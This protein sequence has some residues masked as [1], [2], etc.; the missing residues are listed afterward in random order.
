[1][2]DNDIVNVSLRYKAIKIMV[3]HK[4]HIGINGSDD[5]SHGGSALAHALL[6]VSGVQ[7][8]KELILLP[9]PNNNHE[10]MFNAGQGKIVQND[11]VLYPNPAENVLYLESK[12]EITGSIILY[13]SLGESVK[14]ITASGTKIA[15]PV[16]NLPSGLYIL[17]ANN[18]K[19]R[20][21]IVK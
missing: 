15:I 20:F 3:N 12:N 4:H 13:N 18:E 6:T 11:L 9:E 10:K 7:D 16:E 5:F 1:M 2:M 8:T 17:K 21:S 14:S 19:I